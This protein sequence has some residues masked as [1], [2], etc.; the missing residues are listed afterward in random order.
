MEQME[1][2]VV[3]SKEET[4]RRLLEENVSLRKEKENL[5]NVLEEMTAI[6]QSTYTQAIE[7]IFDY[8]KEKTT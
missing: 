6:M 8:D 7:E 3:S 2:F 1:A 4:I 5:L